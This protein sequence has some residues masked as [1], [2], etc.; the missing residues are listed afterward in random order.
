M[1]MEWE[2]FRLR[3]EQLALKIFETIQDSLPNGCKRIDRPDSIGAIGFDYGD[4]G[5]IL[6]QIEDGTLNV[7]N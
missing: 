1:E 5:Y 6:L 2:T 4:E 7:S 3:R